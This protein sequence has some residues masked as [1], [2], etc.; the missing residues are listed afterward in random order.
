[1]AGLL[2]L[3]RLNQLSSNYVPPH[4]QSMDPV[5]TQHQALTVRLE[6]IDSSLVP[7]EFSLE[8]N[9]ILVPQPESSV[10]ENILLDDRNNLDDDNFDQR[11]SDMDK[12]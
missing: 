7:N 6:L 3:E 2:L 5:H 4:K 12:T 8:V 9:N 10:E 1:M 11:F